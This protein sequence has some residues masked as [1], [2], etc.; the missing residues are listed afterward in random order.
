MHAITFGFL[1]FIFTVLTR[2]DILAFMYAYVLF[3]SCL[4]FLFSPDINPII[5]SDME[6]WSIL[7]YTYLLCSVFSNPFGIL[8]YMR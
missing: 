4:P 7:T 3:S 5:S 1:A 2:V 8:V 6:I